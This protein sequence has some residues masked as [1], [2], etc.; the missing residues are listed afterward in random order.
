MIPIWLLLYILIRTHTGS[1]QSSLHDCPA[2]PH[3]HPLIP[4]RTRTPPLRSKQTPVHPR[5]KL[6]MPSHS[7][8]LPSSPKH[9]RILQHILLPRWY[10]VPHRASIR[11][12]TTRH[13]ITRTQQDITQM[14]TPTNPPHRILMPR[15]HR[16]RPRARHPYIKRADH[17]VH[18]RRRNNRVPVLVPVVRERLA[19]RNPHARC[20]A[21]PRFRRRVDRHAHCEVVARARRG[22][23]IKYP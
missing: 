19:R 4:P 1:S 2:I 5:H 3:H 14:R 10:P 21:H 9:H 18:A 23:K 16:N 7:P 15:Q 13:I 12:H 22:A 11:P 8:H 20:G 17:P 6:R